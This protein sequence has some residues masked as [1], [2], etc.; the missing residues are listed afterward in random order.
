M[1]DLFSFAYRTLRQNNAKFISTIP[2]GYFTFPDGTFHG[3]GSGNKYFVTTFVS[4][5]IVQL[6]ETI[7]IEVYEDRVVPPPLAS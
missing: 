4:L 1:A 3:I 2:G 6:L 7:K 5:G